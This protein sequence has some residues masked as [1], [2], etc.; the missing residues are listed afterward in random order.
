MLPRL[1]TPAEGGGNQ[2]GHFR[3]RWSRC[4]PL[5]ERNINFHLERK[6]NHL[7]NLKQ[8]EVNEHNNKYPYETKFNMKKQGCETIHLPSHPVYLVSSFT[9]KIKTCQALS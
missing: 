6:H 4:P 8:I 1:P 5:I 2:K 7:Q 9:N 3:L